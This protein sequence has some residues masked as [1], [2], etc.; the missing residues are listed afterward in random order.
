MTTLTANPPRILNCRGENPREKQPEKPEGGRLH[1]MT[2]ADGCDA[3]KRPGF[4]RQVAG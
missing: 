4:I 2:S 3:G 1:A